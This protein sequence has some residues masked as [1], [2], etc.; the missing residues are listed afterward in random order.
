MALAQPIEQRVSE[1]NGQW[2]ALLVP[3]ITH[4]AHPKLLDALAERSG[5]S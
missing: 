4:L 3:S 1:L 5:A 2:L